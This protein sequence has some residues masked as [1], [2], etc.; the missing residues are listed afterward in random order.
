MRVHST[1]NNTLS[2]QQKAA[3][4]AEKG[5]IVDDTKS[6]KPKDIEENP[7]KER[8]GRSEILSRLK[9]HKKAI[10]AESNT[11]KTKAKAD[12]EEPKLTRASWDKQIEEK[13]VLKPEEAQEKAKKLTGESKGEGIKV[14][15]MDK[16]ALGDVGK[17]KPDDPMTRSKLK[18]VLSQ[19]SFVFSEKE[20]NALEDIL[21]KDKP[22]K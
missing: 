8:L 1:F 22:E 7:P 6:A 19:G 21:G 15:D 11:E 16:E 14:I 18:S 12:T 2:V 3:Q 10:I 20:R 4:Q 17:N 13:P 9:N 5:S